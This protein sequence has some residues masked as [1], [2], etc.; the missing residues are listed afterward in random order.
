M[1]KPKKHNQEWSPNDE[2]QLKK[3]IKK[4]T[5]TKIMAEKLKRTEQAI[6]SKADRLNKSV[7]PKDK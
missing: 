6:R 3:L 5:P 2:Q 7:M 1:K 4:E